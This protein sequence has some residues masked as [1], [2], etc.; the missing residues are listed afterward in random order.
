MEAVDTTS[1]RWNEGEFRPA[2]DGVVARPKASYHAAKAVA[3]RALGLVLLVLAAPFIAVL[4]S[5]EGRTTRVE[6]LA[7]PA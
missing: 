5:R 7:A 2:A 1:A 4:L 3:D 6:S